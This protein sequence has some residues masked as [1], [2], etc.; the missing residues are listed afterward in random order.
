MTRQELKPNSIISLTVCRD[1]DAVDEHWESAN[2]IKTTQEWYSWYHHARGDQIPEHDDW[3]I[4]LLMGGRGC[5][6]TRA[7]AEWVRYKARE[8]GRIA[9]IA[10]TFNDARE[11]M[12]EGESGLLHIGL[13]CERPRYF[14]SRRLLEWPN[15][16]VGYLFSAE[17]PDSL[18]GPQFGAAW[19][20]E[21]AAW[22]YPEASLSN[23][24]L[25]LR[26]GQNPQLTITT[27]PRSTPAMMSLVKTKGLLET[28]ATTDDNQHHLSEVF[29]E[30]MDDAYGQTRL[31]RQELDGEL[32]TDYEGALWTHDL[33][34]IAYYQGE[35]PKFDK[36]IISVDPPVSSHGQSD[37]CGVIVAGS[38]GTGREA[39]AY[40]LQDDT[41]QGLSPTSWAK[42]AIM[43]YHSWDA[44]GLL[45][46]RNQGGDLVT[47]LI[48]NL[49]A[50]VPVKTVF[51]TKSK[52][53]RAEPVAMLYE[54]GRVFHMRRFKEL[55]SELLQ[56][57]TKAMS[58][59]PD[60]ADA[61]VWA[62]THLLLEAKSGP[63]IRRL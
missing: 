49:D 5:G 18:R 16:S 53:A 9:L 29:L 60:R 3:L 48:N 62:V 27:T 26:M 41:T 4:W 38:V 2:S 32:L 54:Q 59:S 14:P 42:R 51:A 28:H 6:K 50:T 47:T 7:G 44:N 58:H 13:P 35:L 10:P 11:V 46:E 15:G 12:L 31:G 30:A 36:I 40:I 52:A 57:G 55:E 24:R 34:D 43:L 39:R 19:A 33:L 23:L 8:T 61:L 1:Q 56:L 25:G 20:D 45:V 17:D 63:N 37:K 22:T 21:Y